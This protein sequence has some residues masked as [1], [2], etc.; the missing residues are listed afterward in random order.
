MAIGVTTIS[1]AFGEV[2]SL[3]GRSSVSLAIA[4]LPL[5]VLFLHNVVIQCDSLIK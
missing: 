4:E 2:V 3:M 5:A 1:I